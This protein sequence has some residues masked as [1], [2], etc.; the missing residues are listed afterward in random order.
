MQWHTAC[1]EARES[2]ENMDHPTALSYSSLP[3]WTHMGLDTEGGGS[4]PGWFRGRLLWYGLFSCENPIGASD[5]KCR[6]RS[7]SP[8]ITGLTLGRAAC[9]PNW[10]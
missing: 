6:V 7:L 1:Q 3:F 4:P 8:T 5:S 2:R 10:E 9:T